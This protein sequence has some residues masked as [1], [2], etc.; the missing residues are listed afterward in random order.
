MTKTKV[1]A[2]VNGNGT[3][4]GEMPQFDTILTTG[5][6]VFEAWRE[7]G[8]ELIEF[9]KARVDQGMEMGSAVA[10]SASFNE[11]ME[12]QVKFAQ[13]TMNDFLAQASKLTDMSTRPIIESFAVLRK[14]TRGGTA[15]TDTIR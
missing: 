14:T 3:T 4:F 15:T 9:S 5:S 8:A 10:R 11:V 1:G 13:S 7:I 6:R 12:L 2:R